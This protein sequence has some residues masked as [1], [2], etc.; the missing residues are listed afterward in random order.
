MDDNLA[1]SVVNFLHRR[2]SGDCCWL[3]KNPS[4]RNPL[5]SYLYWDHSHWIQ[6]VP[7]GNLR[8]VPNRHEGFSSP[9]SS[10]SYSHQWLNYSILLLIPAYCW[11]NSTDCCI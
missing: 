6:R 3:I 5:A 11:Q 7:S 1:D 10:L 4:E 9:L 2:W 8:S